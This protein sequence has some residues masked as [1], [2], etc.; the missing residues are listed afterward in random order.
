MQGISWS[1]H[2][3]LKRDSARW[4]YASTSTDIVLGRVIIWQNRL[5]NSWNSPVTTLNLLMLPEESYC[6]Y[7]THVN[8]TSMS[9]WYNIGL[10][11]DDN[12]GV[13]CMFKLCN[14]AE[15]IYWSEITIHKI[16]FQLSL[17]H[18]NSAQHFKRTIW[19]IMSEVLCIAHN[20]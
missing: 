4:S 6:P 3:L 18:Q 19:A 10:A 9:S 15:C 2:Q 13:Y 14:N 11:A 8:G 5:H 1:L 20:I 17:Y 7:T 12:F 16:V